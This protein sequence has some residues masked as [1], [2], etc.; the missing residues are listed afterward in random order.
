[1]YEIGLI[2]RAAEV[3][4]GGG[5]VVY[6]TET[7]YGIGVDAMNE[8]TILSAFRI[9]RRPLDMPLFIAVCSF[10]MMEDVALLNEEEMEIAKA[11]LPGPVSILVLKKGCVPSALTA[12][13]SKVGLR[14]PSHPVALKLIEASGP[15]T[16]T[17]ANITGKP[18]PVSL[19]ELDA[20]IYADAD[21]VLD[22]GRCDYGSASTFV[23]LSGKRVIRKGAGYEKVESV[24]LE[25][26]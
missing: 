16:S 9:K 3:I 13:S 5:I 22:G 20:L 25:F 1:M 11:L 8:E 10:E 19:Q 26:S 6:P 21:I 15:I 24:L 7:V 18:S 14:F 17:S 2:R 12:G 23:D 4:R